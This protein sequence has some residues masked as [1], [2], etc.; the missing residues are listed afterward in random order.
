MTCDV[1]GEVKI[2]VNQGIGGEKD[3]KSHDPL[4]RPTD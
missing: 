3:H 2:V 1:V 4:I